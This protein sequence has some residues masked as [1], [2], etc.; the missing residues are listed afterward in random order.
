MLYRAQKFNA[1][2]LFLKWVVGGGHALDLDMSRL[3]LEG[4][5]RV[6]GEHE[7]APYDECRADVLVRYLVVIFKLL[8]LENDLKAL[9]AGAVVELNKAE[10]FHIADGAC[11]AAYGYLFSAEALRVGKYLS[12][13]SAFQS[14]TLQYIK[15]KIKGKKH[16]I[17][18]FCSLQEN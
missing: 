14:K 2:A 10:V 11:P 12:D 17:L 15:I 6:G 16:Y 13:L 8:A 7:L 1:V 9:E 18:I 3:Q 4:L 5:L